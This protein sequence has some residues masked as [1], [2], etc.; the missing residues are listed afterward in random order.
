MPTFSPCRRYAAAAALIAAIAWLASPAAVHADMV[1][2]LDL[3]SDEFTK[4]DVTRD[5]VLAAIAAAGADGTA[6]FSGR[7]LNGLDLSGLDLRRLKLQ[8]ARI[9]G[10]NFAG[11]NL[12]GVVLDQAW[13]LKSDFTKANLKGAS[14]FS[15]QLMDAKM[16]GADFAGARIAADF[17]RADLKG[18]N[19]AGADLSADMKNQSMGLMRGVFR[20]SKLEGASFKDANLAR[21]LMEYASLRDADLSGANLMGSELAGADLTGAN[22]ADANFNGADVNSARLLSLRGKD[23]ARNLDGVKNLDRAYVE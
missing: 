2:H 14:L 4:A 9:N 8:S 23:K 6:D 11:A 20:S 15:T 5:D 3:K 7:R 16:P 13:A 10:A 1:D 21:V 19:F 17:S 18:A 12:E 22:V